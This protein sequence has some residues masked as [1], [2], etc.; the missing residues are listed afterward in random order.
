MN[1]QIDDTNVKT[2]LFQAYDTNHDGFFDFKEFLMIMVVVMDG[3][4]EQKLLKVK[5]HIES[6]STQVLGSKNDWK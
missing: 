3:T 2:H 1:L 6:T 4:Q 5:F